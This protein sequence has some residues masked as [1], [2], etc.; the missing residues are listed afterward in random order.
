MYSAPAPDNEAERLL[1]LYACGVLDSGRE[2]IFDQLTELA[3]EICEA[4][5][6][7]VSLVD[8][9]RQW[10]KSRVGL[11]VA[12]TARSVSFCAHAI[13]QP[14]VFVVPDTYSD[15][16]FADN[17]LVTGPPNIRFYAGAP[18]ITLEGF[19]LGTLCVID[20]KPRTLSDSQMKALAVLRNHL[21]KLVELR[22][23]TR[24]LARAY[25]ELDTFSYAISHDLRA[26]LRA[27]AGFSDVLMEDHGEQLGESGRRVV[28]R[29]K[30]ASRH[31]D[32]FTDDLLELSR[33]QRRPIHLEPVDLSALASEILD[34][35]QAAHP[36]RRV[37]TRITPG[38][39]TL[40]DRVLLAAMVT[41]LLDNAWKFSA[42][43]EPARIEVGREMRDGVE[44]FFIRDN[45]A[46]FDMA[47]AEKL[48]Q[49]FQRLHPAS[50]F[51]GSGIGLATVK[52]IVERHGGVVRAEARPAEGATFRFTLQPLK[53]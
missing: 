36:A 9:N 23:L 37:A 46:G 22:T 10:F 4:P 19:G 30:T 34:G 25:Q 8:N 12:E 48:F 15:P 35:L 26:P 45:G 20:R 50:E 31:L 7:L 32:Q 11:E 1:A 33:A 16:R 5:I 21:Q 17:P 29:I 28:S 38:L 53:H 52:R 39:A 51:A 41:N 49:P 43:A 2:D 47:Y 14:E 42:R 3:A 44:W 40:G 27:I 6:A 24:D 13:L 18:L